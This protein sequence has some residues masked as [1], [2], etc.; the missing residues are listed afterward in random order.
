MVRYMKN[1]K[2]INVLFLTRWY[3]HR[4]DPMPGLFVERHAE[5]VAQFCNVYLI[6]VHVDC[7]T[8]K[9][10]E[11]HEETKN[12]VKVTRIYYRAVKHNIPLASSMVKAYK[13][14]K[15]NWKGIKKLRSEN[16]KIDLIHVNILSRLGIVALI[17]KLKHKTPYII[18]EHW[19]RYLP[20]TNTYHGSF[21]KWI[22]KIVVKNAGAVTTVTANLRDAMLAHGLKN[23]YYAIVPNVLL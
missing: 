16:R 19:S 18:T 17:E 9:K 10:Y 11:I 1:E 12:N 8:E 14:L 13:F 21:R 6:Y 22:T 20:I 2:K 5:A 4:Y 23:K 3:P 15:Y 7:E